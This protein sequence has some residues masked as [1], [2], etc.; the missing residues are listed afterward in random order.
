MSDRAVAGLQIV[1]DRIYGRRVSRLE[2]IKRGSKFGREARPEER[3]V[4]GQGREDLSLADVPNTERSRRG[5]NS[6]SRYACW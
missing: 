4:D 3:G 5:W 2:V 6:R 1:C